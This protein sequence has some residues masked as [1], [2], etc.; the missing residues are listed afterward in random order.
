[1][2]TTL[3]FL[4]AQMILEDIM[5]CEINQTWKRKMCIIWPYVES[6]PVVMEAENGRGV[7]RLSDWEAARG[8]SVGTKSGGKG[9][10]GPQEH[11]IVNKGETGFGFWRQG[12]EIN[13]NP[14]WT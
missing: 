8:W 1:M 9:S 5:L 3:S 7:T 13:L 12:L 2:D 14:S 10:S 6:K 11:A 4:T